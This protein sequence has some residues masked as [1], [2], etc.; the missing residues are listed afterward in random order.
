MVKKGRA[1]NYTAV[2]R[3]LTSNAFYELKNAFC[4][5]SLSRYWLLAREIERF[6]YAIVTENVAGMKA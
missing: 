1:V 3:L 6:F 4:A 5:T 2:K